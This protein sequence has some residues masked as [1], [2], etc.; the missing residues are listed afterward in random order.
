MKL[1]MLIWVLLL[2][3]TA[4]ADCKLNGD[5]KVSGLWTSFTEWHF[6]FTDGKLTKSYT[7]DLPAEDWPTTMEIQSGKFLKL[8]QTTRASDTIIDTILHLKITKCEDPHV[9]L[10]PLRGYEVYLDLKDETNAA[11]V[12]PTK[13]LELKKQ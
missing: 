13:E 8:S 12:F 1:I 11:S 5:F 3:G 10:M 6:T 9:E 7:D 4:L 2:S